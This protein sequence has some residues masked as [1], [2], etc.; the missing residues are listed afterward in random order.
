VGLLSCNVAKI[1]QHCFFEF[2]FSRHSLSN[3]TNNDRPIVSNKRLLV[4][5]AGTAATNNLVRSLKSGDPSMHVVGC[6]DDRFV[7]K[8]SNCDQKYLAPASSDTT[9]LAALRRIIRRERIQL[10]IPNHEPDVDAVS[11]VR[12]K[13]LCRTFLPRKATIAKCED[14]YALMRLL[15]SCG[16]PVPR[17]YAIRSIGEIEGIFQRFPTS[18]QLWCRIRRG[19]G[20][21]GAIPV[22]N[23][24]QVRAWIRYWQ[25]MRGVPAGLF[26]LSQYLP[27]RDLTVQCLF[28]RGQLFAAKMYERLAYHVSG[29]SVS[30]VSSSASLAKMIAD[31]DL[32][33]LC[34]LAVRVIDSRAS[35][36]FFVDLKEDE[37]DAPR[38]TE[39]NAGR[40][41]NIPTI[42]DVV[43]PGNMA[44]A[45][46]RLA[47]DEPLPRV[48]AVSPEESQ[49]VL[50]GLDTLPGV[51]GANQLFDGISD[52]TVP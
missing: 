50:R 36:V 3:Y 2:A 49:Y 19:A 26:T 37:Q 51:F 12:R 34:V 31:P 27:G 25:E 15:R 41:A 20:S 47:F 9:F 5:R 4:L 24:L 17:T 35:G 6:H 33:K 18:A 38:I 13:L 40:F 39:I 43:G 8:Q 14:K 32:L 1:C 23:P 52:A 45:Y 29:T 48:R 44:L 30:G 28:K 21:F 10:V 46:V 42:H 7:L 16:L 22:R 11:K